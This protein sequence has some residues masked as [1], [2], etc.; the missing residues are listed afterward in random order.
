MN[1]EPDICV[2]TLVPYVRLT[3]S[4]TDYT[5]WVVVF[6]PA[7]Y[8]LASQPVPVVKSKELVQVDVF[9]DGPK[10]RPAPHNVALPFKVALPTPVGE[11]PT[12]ALD[13]KINVT[14]WLD[15]PEDEGSTVIIYDEAE[16][17]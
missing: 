10:K 9:I 8:R 12:P 7:N 5:L 13:A 16:E 15:D 4:G 2:S 11:N 14:V 6:L 17:E 1:P 3:K